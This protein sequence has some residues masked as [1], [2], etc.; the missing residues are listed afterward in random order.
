MNYF[1]HANLFIPSCVTWWRDNTYTNTFMW[2]LIFCLIHYIQV[3][4][5]TLQLNQALKYWICAFNF[6]QWQST[7]PPPRGSSI[8][9]V[10]SKAIFQALSRSYSDRENK[11]SPWP[12]NF[13]FVN[14][15]HYYTT[16]GC[17]FSFLL[18]GWKCTRYSVQ[19]STNFVT[20]FIKQ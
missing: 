20:K 14:T 10:N 9:L 8:Y 3:P 7:F 15:W 5:N 6:W 4:E 12:K 18:E 19:S 13:S 17:P 1:T 11:L 16:T 2:E